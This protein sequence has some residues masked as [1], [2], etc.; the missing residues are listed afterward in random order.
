VRAEV[1]SMPQRN[2]LFFRCSRASTPLT[3]LPHHASQQDNAQQLK[4]VDS[5]GYKL[6][7]KASFA[8]LCM[9]VGWGIRI[10][11]FLSW[12]TTQMQWS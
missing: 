2:M 4:T 3:A 6:R 11:L 9:W 1:L 5:E 10:H 7:I 8:E 12:I